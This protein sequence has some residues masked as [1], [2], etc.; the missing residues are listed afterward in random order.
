[1]DPH[2]AKDLHYHEVIARE[3]DG[4]VVAPRH[5]TN[6]ALYA[7]F[8]RLI[9]GERLLDLGCGTGHMSLRFGGRFKHVV[10]VDH[11][12]AMLAVARAKAV[13]RGWKH[14]E[15]VCASVF[16]FIA[17]APDAG[18]DVLCCIGFLHHLQAADLAPAAVQFARLLRPGALLLASEPVR[19]DP[20]AVPARIQ[21]WNAASVAARLDYSVAVAQPD[22]APIELEALLGALSGAGFKLLKTARNWEIFPHHLPPTLRDRVTIRLLNCLYGKAGNVFT[23]AARKP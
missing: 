21:A 7:S 17:G 12:Q 9:R 6:D 18:F 5:V 19:V 23:V 2:I 1:L 20:A 3:Y 10:A 13:A 8:S 22:E 4:V 14:I 16:D 15:F 11:S